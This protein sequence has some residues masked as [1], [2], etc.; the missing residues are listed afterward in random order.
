MF[1]SQKPQVE[2]ERC[3]ARSKESTRRHTGTTRS[4][5]VRNANQQSCMC[6]EE[7]HTNYA[8]TN[9][10]DNPTSSVENS[11]GRIILKLLL[12]WQHGWCF[13]SRTRTNIALT[14]IV[15][16]LCTHT[17]M[18]YIMCAQGGSCPRGMPKSKI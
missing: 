5:K 11:T 9:I 15:V 12:S 3:R 17:R 7:L 18:T 16:S 10:I 14:D 1:R 13:R 2:G 8:C 4:E 6:I